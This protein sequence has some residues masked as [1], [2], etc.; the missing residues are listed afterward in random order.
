MGEDIGQGALR[1]YGG[2]PMSFGTASGSGSPSSGISSSGRFGSLSVEADLER[3]RRDACPSAHVPFAAADGALLRVRVPGGRLAAADLRAVADAAAHSD[4]SIIE[5]TN[6]AN[7]QLRGY[8]AGPAQTA[9]DGLIAAGLVRPDLDE[10][11][12]RN[13]IGSPLAGIDAEALDT[14]P[15]VDAIDAILMTHTAPLSPKFGVIVDGGGTIH[16]RGRRHDLV[17]GAAELDGQ[18]VFEI[19]LGDAL[20]IGRSIAA[21]SLVVEPA[22]AAR[23]VAAVLALLQPGERGGELTKRIGRSGVVGALTAVAGCRVVASDAITRPTE[24]AA[25]PI[26]RGSGWVAGAP[27]LGRTNTDG[28]RALADLAEQLG[29]HE[30]R[31][32][33]WRSVVVPLRSDADAAAA[34]ARLV[35]IGM[36][37]DVRQPAV[38]VIACAGSSGCTAGEAD[39]QADARTLIDLLGS[40]PQ[41]RT[42]HLSGCPKRCAS[43]SANMLTLVAAG[44]LYDVYDGTDRIADALS[45]TAALALASGGTI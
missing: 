17:F 22:A 36:C 4:N 29:A 33:P 27:S 12:R 40:A 35:A 23:V 18:S 14:K 32:T 16:L 13:V 28:M 8:A 34:E 20:A 19:A 24:P 2:Q 37:T 1:R 44:G 25:I 39:T 11:A 43:R 10:D 31:I 26:G 9:L 6:R 3:R 42:I 45:P 38:S 41:S 21:T 15:V 7:L 5:L 30:V